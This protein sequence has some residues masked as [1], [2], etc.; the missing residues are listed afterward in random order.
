MENDYSKEFI[1]RT[2][3]LFDKLLSTDFIHPH[4]F[5]KKVIPYVNLG[6]EVGVD[7]DGT[8]NLELVSK[9]GS[10]ITDYVDFIPFDEFFNVYTI[11]EMKKAL[12]MYW[13]RKNIMG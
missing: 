1:S 2:V 13:E 7:D 8:L 10:L 4:Y 9:E 11:D 12:E 3:D 5:E 6:Y